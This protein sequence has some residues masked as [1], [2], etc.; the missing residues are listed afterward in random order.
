MMS[1]TFLCELWRLFRFSP[2][3]P[4][5]IM[6]KCLVGHISADVLYAGEGTYA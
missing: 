1:S 4:I 3:R 2:S 6:K 5:E